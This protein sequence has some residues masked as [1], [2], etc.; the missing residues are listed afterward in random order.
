MENDI[1]GGPQ[2]NSSTI[3]IIVCISVLVLSSS[4]L[5]IFFIIK[6]SQQ[7]HYQEVSKIGPSLA[8]GLTAR[9]RRKSTAHSIEEGL[10]EIQRQTII[11]KS[12]ERR[13]P[14]LRPRQNSIILESGPSASKDTPSPGGLID[15]WKKWEATLHHKKS[16]SLENHPAIGQHGIE[17]GNPQ[18]QHDQKNV[19]LSQYHFVASAFRPVCPPPR[20]T[21]RLQPTS[22]PLESPAITH[23]EGHNR[24]DNLQI[25]ASSTQS[26]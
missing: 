25:R 4:L 16:I 22:L 10:E 8:N 24:D 7:R 11:K 21:L 14:L 18:T 17:M 5:A 13:T 23:L 20:S 12:I 9:L 26:Q 3:W 2:I 1:Q 19:Q 6:K 15:D